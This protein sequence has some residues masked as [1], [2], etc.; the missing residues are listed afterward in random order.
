MGHS[1]AEMQRTPQPGG[2]STVPAI[3]ASEA[4]HGKEV[5][6]GSVSVGMAATTS[7]PTAAGRGGGAD[8]GTG[9]ASST[10][11]RTAKAEVPTLTP[12]FKSLHQELLT[13]VDQLYSKDRS[14]DIKVIE[15]KGD[16]ITEQH[17]QELKLRHFS[18]VSTPARCR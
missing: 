6:N 1:D 7:T 9:S 2:V 12:A 3:P 8:T 15:E 14:Y 17:R 16:L 4:E 5:D 18:K 10:K 13:Q 11:G